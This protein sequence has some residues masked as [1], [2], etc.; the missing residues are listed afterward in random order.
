[1]TTA[2]YALIVSI[3][4]AALSLFALI[5]NIWQKYIFVRPTLDVGFGV[6]QIMQRSGPATMRP[7]KDVLQVSVTNMGPGQ[8]ILHNLICRKRRWSWRWRR[9]FEYAI[10]IPIDGDPTVALPSGKG[11]FGGGLPHKMDAGEV[12]QFFLPYDKDCMLGAC[13]NRVGVVDTYGRNSWCSR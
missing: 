9:R 12:K 6:Y 7:T 13:M 11:P 5:W 10:L 3:S 1:M 8:V 4:S 2:D